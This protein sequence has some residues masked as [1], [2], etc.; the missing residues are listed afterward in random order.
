MYNYLS[1]LLNN[2]MFMSGVAF[3]FAIMLLNNIIYLIFQCIE[4]YFKKKLKKD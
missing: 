4:L 1:E 2:D 3:T